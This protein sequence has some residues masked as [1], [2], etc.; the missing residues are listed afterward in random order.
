[1]WIRINDF[2]INLDN[3]TNINIEENYVYV[4]FNHGVTRL[5]EGYDH[6]VYWNSLR[7]D[8]NDIPDSAWQIIRTLPKNSMGPDL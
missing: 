6:E 4:S 7:F 2:I 3:V 1:M 5:G 8:K